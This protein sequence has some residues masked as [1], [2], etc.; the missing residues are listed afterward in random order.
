MTV[1][2]AGELL[3]Q[4]DGFVTAALNPEGAHEDFD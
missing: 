3:T 4:Q 2:S 1:C